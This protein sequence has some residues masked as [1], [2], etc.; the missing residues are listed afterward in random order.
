[1]KWDLFRHIVIAL[2]AITSSGYALAQCPATALT[3]E[4]PF[5]PPPP[6]RSVLNSPDRVWYGSESLWTSI[7]PAFRSIGKTPIAVK[8]VY[9]RVGFDLMNEPNPDL[10][11]IA[12]RLDKASPVVS[13]DRPTAGKLHGDDSPTGMAMI[14]VMRFPSEGCWEV[15]ANYKGKTLTWIVAVVP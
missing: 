4:H 5:V 6:Y 1:M 10:T 11:V 13:S 14:T 3:L 7:S 15:A 12:K 8:L 2:A 9:W